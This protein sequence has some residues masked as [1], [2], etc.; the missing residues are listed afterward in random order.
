MSEDQMEKISNAIL[1]S[2]ERAFDEAFIVEQFSDGTLYCV[3]LK[4][5]ST[6]QMTLHFDEA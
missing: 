4:D 6:Y 3:T 2:L 5:G 1:K